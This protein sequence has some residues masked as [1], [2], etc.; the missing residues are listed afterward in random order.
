M[1]LRELE[2]LSVTDPPEATRW[3]EALLDIIDA[4]GDIGQRLDWRRLLAMAFAHSNE[5]ERSVAICQ[6]AFALPGAGS[7][8]IERAR[9]RLAMMQPL[10]MT[11]RPLDGI[12]AGRTA[13]NVFE[14]AQRPDL[15]GRAAL[16]IGAIY[17][18]IGQPENA[19]PY[20]DLARDHLGAADPLALGQIETNRGTALAA[21]DRFEDAERAF[22]HAIALLDDSQPDSTWAVAI[23]ESNRADLAGRQ[24]DIRR[25]LHH[26]ESA[27]RHFEQFGEWGELGRIDTEEATLLSTLG[28]TSEVQAGFMDAIE[29]LRV[30]GAPAALAVAE[31]AYATALLDSGD[32]PAATD[33]IAQTSSRIDSATDVG[34]YRQLL[35][36]QTRI[37]LASNRTAEADRTIEI[38]LRS[39]EDLPIQQLRWILLQADSAECRGELEQSRQLLESALEQSSIARSTPLTGEILQRLAALSRKLDESARANEYARQAIR[40]FEQIRGSLHANRLRQSW[41][42]ERARVYSDLYRSLIGESDSAAQIEAFELAEKIRGRMLLDALHQDIE[43]IDPET[44]RSESERKLLERANRHRRWLNWVYSSLAE[45]NEPRPDLMAEIENR[46]TELVRLTG[47]LATLDPRRSRLSEPIEYQDAQNLIDDSTAVISY[48]SSGESMSAQVL[49]KNGITGFAALA[50]P[51]DISSQVANLQFQIGR[52]LVHGNSQISPARE[53]RLQ[54]DVDIVLGKLYDMLMAPIGP[55]LAG[56]DRLIVI[57]TGHLYSIPF[58]ALRTADDDLVDHFE[59]ATIP[60][61][62]VFSAMHMAGQPGSFAPAQPLIVAVPDD[63]APGLLTEAREVATRFSGA[64]L[65]FQEHATIDAVL[66]AMPNADLIH[67][68]CH[69]RFDS[70]LPNASGLRMSDGWLTLDRLL[71]HRLHNP[72]ILLSGCETGRVRVGDADDLEGMTAT[73]IAAGAAGLVTSLWKTH[74]AAATELVRS[75]YDALLR[76]ETITAALRHAHRW[77]RSRYPHPAMWAPLIAL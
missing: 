38:G 70:R 62:S 41:H 64:S 72:L 50:S 6:E 7:A 54:R 1:L 11:G 47:R 46:E 63:D 51:E 14:R 24:G 73:L 2:Q 76:Q 22:D 69:G 36:L 42:H 49:T 71:T 75:L 18:M 45:G 53:A 68:A 29:R 74:D 60:S 28:L 30:Y 55:A 23:A 20:F 39:T 40:I 21:L 61:L 15:A 12:G 8:P 32:L 26:Y 59:I 35:F 17:A 33:A 10:A 37:A 27:R 4:T 77:V 3:G 48:M 44:A 65:L 13:L 19:L 25:A 9:L 66:Q 56:I 5:F 67:L 34:L 57:P 58:A 31:I 16:N 43:V 52:A